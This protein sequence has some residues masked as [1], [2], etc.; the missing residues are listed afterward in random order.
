MFP[1]TSRGAAQENIHGRMGLLFLLF[2]LG[3]ESN[4]TRLI[5]AADPFW[6]AVR[7]TSESISPRVRV[8]LLRALL[9][10]SQ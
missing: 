10:V 5:E 8:W 9:H 2:Y 1:L 6:P 4:F 7:F 3:L